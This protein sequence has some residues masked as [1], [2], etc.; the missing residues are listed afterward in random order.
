MKH[1]PFAWTLPY[2]QPVAATC[3]SVRAAVVGGSVD[4]HPTLIKVGAQMAS[5]LPRVTNMLYSI[6]GL[7]H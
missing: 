2:V 1:A 6:H 4:R 7:V 5:E 3:G